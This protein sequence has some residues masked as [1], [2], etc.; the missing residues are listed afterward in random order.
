M[1]GL[2]GSGPREYRGPSSTGG[3]CSE[4]GSAWSLAQAAP[5][6]LK[7]WGTLLGRVRKARRPWQAGLPFSPL[8]VRARERSPVSSLTP[9]QLLPTMCPSPRGGSAHG[10]T[11]LACVLSCAS[12]KSYIALDDF[13]EITKK[14]A[15]GIIPT[16]LFLQDDDDDEV[17]GKSPEDLPLRLKVS[18]WPGPPACPGAPQEAVGGRPRPAGNLQG[19]VACPG[20][21]CAARSST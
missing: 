16:D 18:P 7:G 13:V 12:A 6:D 9:T 14:Y 1:A 2:Q 21:A 5:Q 3:K 11:D 10:L 15:K 8:I 19:S 17:A 20:E 4:E